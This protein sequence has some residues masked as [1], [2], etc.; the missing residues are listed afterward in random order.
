MD[1]VNPEQAARTLTEVKD[2]ARRRA[3]AADAAED[4]QG[5]RR[6]R[7]GRQP[8]SFAREITE[9]FSFYNGYDPMFTWWMGMPYKQI[10]KTLQDYA[11]FLREK[12][13]DASVAGD[14]G[15][16]RARSARRRRRSSPRFP[17]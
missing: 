7:R 9:W 17:T 8:T 2:A 15:H 10:D 14:T 3:M 16:G 12:A 11:T 1:D 13:A 6:A 5:H 4:E